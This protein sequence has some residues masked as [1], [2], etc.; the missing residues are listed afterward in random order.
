MTLNCIKFLEFVPH[1]ILEIKLF[2]LLFLKS[3]GFPIVC[4]AEK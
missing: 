1:N 2:F 3:L 4:N